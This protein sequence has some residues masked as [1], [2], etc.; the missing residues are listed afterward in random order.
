[1]VIS[2]KYS[3]TS[4]V[5]TSYAVLCF[6]LVLVSVLFLADMSALAEPV[7]LFTRFSL[8]V[9]KKEM[10][11]FAFFD[12]PATNVKIT[13]FTVNGIPLNQKYQITAGPHP[14][15]NRVFLMTIRGST[16]K[17]NPLKYKNY[18]AGYLIPKKENGR[19]V[20]GY[21][22]KFIIWFDDNYI[23][24]VY[25]DTDA[26]RINLREPPERDLTRFDITI[27]GKQALNDNFKF[28]KVNDTH[29]VI[30]LIHTKELPKTLEYK[31]YESVKLKFDASKT[32]SPWNDV[33][34]Y[35]PIV[36]IPDKTD[37]GPL[38]LVVLTPIS[39]YAGL[40]G[41]STKP[42]IHI[43]FNAEPYPPVTKADFTINNGQPLP[44]N[45]E[46][47][48]YTNLEIDLRHDSTLKYATKIVF[49]SSGKIPATVRFR[50]LPKIN[51]LPNRAVKFTSAPVVPLTAKAMIHNSFF[52]GHDYVVITIRYSGPPDPQPKLTDF[53]YNNGKQFKA[54][55]T[56]IID[57][58]SL[59][60]SW[61]IDDERGTLL[62]RYNAE[63]ELVLRNGLPIP[64]IPRTLELPGY[65]P[66]TLIKNVE[67]PFIPRSGAIQPLT[68]PV[69][70]SEQ[71]LLTKPGADIPVKDKIV[72]N[73]IANLS[74][75]DDWIELLNI[76]D[77]P[78]SLDK[79]V[80]SI[81]TEY[82]DETE[83]IRFPDISIPA[84]GI[85]L[86][87]NRDPAN[88]A[89]AIGHNV[90]VNTSD[91]PPD[92]DENI[93]YLIVKDEDNYGFISPGID[94]PN[95]NDWMLILR[96]GKPWDVKDGT[97]VYNSGYQIEDV[98]G[99][100]SIT[101]EIDENEINPPKEKNKD[102]TAG[103]DLWHTTV[104]PLNGR[105]E[106][107]EMLLRFDRTLNEGTVHARDVNKHGF[108]VH[109][110]NPVPFTGIGYDS[111]I[112]DDGGHLG[113]PG[114]PN[115][116]ASNVSDLKT[117]RFI[118][119]ELMLTTNN[120]KNAQWIELHNTSQSEA[121][122]LEDPDGDGALTA[123]KMTIENHNSG[124]WKRIRRNLHVEVDLSEW[125]Q[126]IPPRQKVLIAAFADRNSGASDFP[127]TRVATLW[128]THRRSF[129]MIKRGNLFLNASGGFT[130]KITDSQGNVSDIVG[131]LD[132]IAVDPDEGI[133][134]DD[135]VG[136]D[137]PTELIKDGHRTSL[138][139]LKNTDGSP[140][141]GIPT[142]IPTRDGSGA[143]IDKHGA[144]LPLGSDAS[145]DTGSFA[146]QHA[147]D[148]NLGDLA[149]ITWFGSEDDISTPLNT[150]NTVM[151]VLL[152]F[153]HP[154]TENGE[155][156]IR[157][158]TEAEL[159][160]AGFHILRSETRNGHFKRIN[161]QLIQGAGSTAERQTYEWIDTTA[162]PGV[163]YYYQI[164]DVSF[165][166][167]RYRLATTKLKGLVS[168]KN[169]LTTQWGVLKRQE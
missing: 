110:F 111:D 78:Q 70:D 80:L 64:V 94:L 57:N 56:Y 21:G 48:P 154:I 82:N 157:W 81:V 138:I 123:W 7:P 147:A 98:A 79:W 91:H 143:A 148:I 153:F 109:S 24:N 108:E 117:G 84:G 4:A 15:N 104:F 155:V 167:E 116:V 13:D 61:R 159:D 168:A 160:N 165:S 88:T 77:S 102:G 107:S 73:E 112:T 17:P 90:K 126:Y 25:F 129:S 34:G 106:T 54:E 8:D 12:T 2:V 5:K 26:I 3:K 105:E 28:E 86:L 152:S 166:G 142:R 135:P 44:D 18:T 72:M 9:A 151:P 145:S 39:L 158:T 113:T 97:N 32:V 22:A 134:H 87:V 10:I 35:E 103:D 132:G 128:E 40:P 85:L 162:K 137:W 66:V 46:I 31:N 75:E 63:G 141:T 71:G 51:L 27:N 122:S 124:S 93:F 52:H 53:T 89:L 45:A 30:N 6:L 36:G 33:I 55:G 69:T 119:S 16:E 163:V 169:K 118:V 49:G 62:A 23:G 127:S 1:M 19:I 136:F 68:T 121:I 115:V 60:T 14:D 101:L 130:I 156:L 100:A 149:K 133:G 96:S 58:N 59:E 50:N 125:F 92:A 161:T 164:E 43:Q 139:R 120:G 150:E 67:V 37:Q 76:S 131:N 47:E 29:Y 144:A 114:Y 95:H 83:I 74:D 20:P 65:H 146:W 11:F 99:P 42:Q 140:R 41:I 38:G